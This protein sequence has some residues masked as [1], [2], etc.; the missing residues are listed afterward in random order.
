M[1]ISC[2]AERSLPCHPEVAFA[3]AVDPDR[4]PSFFTG[5]GPIPAVRGVRLHAPVAVGSTR[6]VHNADG[7]V[8][9]E[10][11]TAHDP[12]VQH[13]YRLTGFRA[14]FAWLV[15]EGAANWTIAGHEDGSRVCWDYEFTLTRRWLWPL[16][17]PLIKIFM[18]RAMHRCLKK[19]A[20][21]SASFTPVAAPSNDQS[22]PP[23]RAGAGVRDR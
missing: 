23:P 1:F 22:T 5:F 6:D 16:A 3:M 19:M 8:L 18:A 11:I 4:F 15:T 7:S 13:A 20:R 10:T 2:H 17:A 21:A 12:P 14:P 9:L